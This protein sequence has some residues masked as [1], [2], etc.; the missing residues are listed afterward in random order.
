MR[1]N[2]EEKSIT[3]DREDFVTGL[4]R[5]QLTSPGTGVS[6]K[7]NETGAVRADNV[8]P[9]RTVPG[10]L[11]PGPDFTSQTGTPNSLLVSA[12]VNT[13]GSVYMLGTNVHRYDSATDTLATTGGFPRTIDHGHATED[14]MQGQIAIYGSTSQLVFYS[15]RG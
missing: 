13:A 1:I 7:W 8:D 12:V 9:F 4:S 2:Y 11:Y 6:F 3:W 14:G 5:T 10:V 15:A